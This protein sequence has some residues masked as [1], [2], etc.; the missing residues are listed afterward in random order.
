MVESVSRKAPGSSETTTWPTVE[1][2]SPSSWRTTASET[3]SAHLVE[4]LVLTGLV[5]L[6]AGEVVPQVGEVD[7]GVVQTLLGCLG[8][9]VEPVDSSL[10][11]LD[12][13][14][15]LGGG[16][17]HECDGGDSGK[18]KSGRADTLAVVSHERG[19][20]SGVSYAYQVS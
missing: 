5:G 6:E 8:L 12:G 3:W 2:P 18:T 9:V 14:L 20:S 7:P 17:R 11:V 13:R 15:G 1:M 10:D 16:S 19:N 4:A